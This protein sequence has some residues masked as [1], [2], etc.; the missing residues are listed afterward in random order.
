MDTA[1]Y[2]DLIG[3]T[4]LS[5]C[6]LFGGGKSGQLVASEE[7][8]V[9]TRSNKPLILPWVKVDQFVPSWLSRHKRTAT[10]VVMAP[11]QYVFSGRDVPA[12]EFDRLPTI[13]PSI[14]EESKTAAAVEQYLWADVVDGTGWAP[15]VGSKV[16]ITFAD[17]TLLLEDFQSTRFELPFNVLTDIQIRGFTSNSSFRLFGGGF[18]LR[19]AAEGIAT[20]AIVNRLTAKSKSW[21]IVSV[22]SELGRVVLLIIDVQ[23]I[24]VKNFFRRA[25]DRALQLSRRDDEDG[26]DGLVTSLERIADLYE[27]GLLRD[28]EFL[29]MK[30]RLLG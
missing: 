26:R 23:E 17:E 5:T 22:A 19:G 7:G 6:K 4:I 21:V 12:A 18:G 3:I 24:P 25:Q 11:N 29:A 8:L 28:D 27:R 16:K 20:A 1:D 13:K 2:Q 9:F 30:K 15:T 14:V 10:V